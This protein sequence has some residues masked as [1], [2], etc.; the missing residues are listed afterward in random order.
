ME[1]KCLICMQTY[2][3]LLVIFQ[4]LEPYLDGI[5][6]LGWHVLDVI[7]TQLQESFLKVVNFFHESSTLVRWEA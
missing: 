3:G 4:V 2:Y 7:L 1:M 6:I 5:H